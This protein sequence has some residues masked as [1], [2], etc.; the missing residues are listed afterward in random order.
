MKTNGKWLKWLFYNFWIY[1]ADQS[2]GKLPG[3]RWTKRALGGP[4]KE[5]P[6]DTWLFFASFR[7]LF[8]SSNCFCTLRV[9]LGQLGITES[10]PSLGPQGHCCASILSAWY[11][12]YRACNFPQAAAPASSGNWFFKHKMPESSVCF[13]IL[14]PTRLFSVVYK[15]TKKSVFGKLGLSVISAS[16]QS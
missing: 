11:E 9:P 14:H 3:V 2:Y 4:V 16:L 1:N 15:H 5:L 7:F 13:P 10:C 8:F 12:Q 6:S